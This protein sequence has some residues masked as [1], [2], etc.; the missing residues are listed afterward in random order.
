M[1]LTLSWIFLI[2]KITNTRKTE[3]KDESVYV[4]HKLFLVSK[5]I[6]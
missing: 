2:K 6:Y 5:N 3:G 1:S 4:L